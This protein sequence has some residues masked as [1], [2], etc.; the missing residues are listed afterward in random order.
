MGITLLKTDKNG[1][2]YFEDD[3]C[4]KCGG[5]GWIREYDHIEGGVCF[6]C[7]GSGYFLTHWTEMTPEYA[8]HLEALREARR[9]RKIDKFNANIAEHYKTLGLNAE[10]HCWAVLERTFGRKDELKAAGARFNG[11]WWYFAEQKDGWDTAEIDATK[12]IFTNPEEEKIGWNQ[13]LKGYE[14]KEEVQNILRKRREA[15]NKESGS[16]FFGNEGDKV[17]E[18]VT[19]DKIFSFESTDWQGNDCTMYGYKMADTA[20]HHFVWVTGCDPWSVFDIHD[21]DGNFYY[22]REDY[23]ALYGKQFHLTGRVKGHKE[24]EGL[25]ETQMT[26]CRIKAA[27]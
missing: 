12:F 7:Q 15:A 22:R 2:K 5:S 1:T 17:D 18:D 27:K 24:R 21:D 4:P 19:L 13:A 8:A 25:K 10:G 20:K 11:D 9:Q 3:R 23:E 6:K 16:D 26:R 14:I